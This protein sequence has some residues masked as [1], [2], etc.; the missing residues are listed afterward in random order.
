[1]MLMQ[2]GCL[3]AQPVNRQGSVSDCEYHLNRDSGKHLKNDVDSGDQCD[4]DNISNDGSDM[5]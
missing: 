2:D 4:V 1:M 3:F 5:R